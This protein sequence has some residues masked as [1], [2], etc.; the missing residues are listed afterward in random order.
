MFLK[1]YLQEAEQY[2]EDKI[3]EVAV[4]LGI[5]KVGEQKVNRF[6]NMETILHH[7]AEKEIL[8]KRV[9]IQHNGH[10]YFDYKQ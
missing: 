6:G 9:D 10:Y 1:D 4:D 3:E 7:D 5:Y 8:R 2:V